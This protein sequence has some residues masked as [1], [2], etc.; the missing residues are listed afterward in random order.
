MTY[1]L[2][3]MV[4]GIFA[5]IVPGQRM[6]AVL[7]RSMGAYGFHFI[8]DPLEAFAKAP[9]MILASVFSAALIG[10]VEVNHIRAYECLGAGPV[11][12]GAELDGR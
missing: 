8:I 11:N 5:G 3:G 9:V 4:I 10:L 6:A 1:I 7:L 2:P 12:D